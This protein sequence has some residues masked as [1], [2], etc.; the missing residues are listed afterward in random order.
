[1]KKKLSVHSSFAIRFDERGRCIPTESLQGGVTDADYLYELIPPTVSYEER[2]A[3]IVKYLQITPAI[4]A[5][6]F[7]Q[8]SRKI[9]EW[10]NSNDNLKQ[11]TNGI[12][13]PFFSPAA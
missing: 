12:G 3:N 10:L 11:I 1:M 13:V 2:F 8:R 6:E 7:E 5:I 9:L 4:T